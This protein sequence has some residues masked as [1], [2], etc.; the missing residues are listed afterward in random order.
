MNPTN[1]SQDIKQVIK[2]IKQEARLCSLCTSKELISTNPS[3][4]DF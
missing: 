1:S 3:G 2:C 4:S